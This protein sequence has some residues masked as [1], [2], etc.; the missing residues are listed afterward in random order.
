MNRIPINPGKILAAGNIAG[1]EVIYDVISMDMH[2]R[3]ANVMYNGIVQMSVSFDKLDFF[4]EDIPETSVDPRQMD[5]K[6]AGKD[7]IEYVL[8]SGTLRTGF[9]QW[10]TYQSMG[11]VDRLS[12]ENIAVPKHRIYLIN[13]KRY[14]GYKP[15]K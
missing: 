6:Y 1:K 3:L 4:I 14:K 9:K 7:M 11:L 13:G 5:E 15:G 2:N 8:D 10:E 12:G